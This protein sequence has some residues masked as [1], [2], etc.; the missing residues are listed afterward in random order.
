MPERV[1]LS[2]IEN[3]SLRFIRCC[4]LYTGESPA[5]VVDNLGSRSMHRSA[6]RRLLA[7]TCGT[8][9]TACVIKCLILRMLQS[10]V[11]FLELRSAADAADGAVLTRGFTATHFLSDLPAVQRLLLR[12][13][14]TLRP[15]RAAAARVEFTI[16]GPNGKEKEEYRTQLINRRRTNN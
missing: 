5:N 12:Y 7:L 8:K 14:F 13:L 15:R 2:H 11:T 10:R 4:H 3:N 9:K 16:R 1:F 6:A